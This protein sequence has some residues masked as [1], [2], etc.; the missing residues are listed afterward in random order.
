MVWVSG[1]K[2][3][4][5]ASNAGC[6]GLIGAGSMN[7][8]LLKNHIQKAH[9]LTIKPFGINIPLL[10]KDVEK[11]IEV[12]LS[13]KVKI[14][15]TSAGSPKKYTSLLQKEGCI[16]VH[17]TSS[18]DL[19]LKCQDAGVNAVV[20]EGFEAGGH[21]GRDELTTLV[22]LQQARYK[23]KIPIIAAGGIGSGAAI[24]SCLALGADAVQI[25]TLFAATLESSAHDNF[26]R[27]MCE[28]GSAST[29]LRMKKTVPVRLLENKFSNSI[30]EIED[31]GGSPEEL[32]A[33]L[34]KGR[35]KLGMLEGNLT[36]GELEIGQI[37]SE[38]H[39]ILTCDKLVDNLA[40]DFLAARARLF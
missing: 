12:A 20:L 3:A 34:N 38:I 29:F 25:G 21:N 17:V 7:P 39:E 27:A 8:D 4:A 15:F 32:L 24:A 30:K 33:C 13:E 31:R 35:A 19:A 18:V 28:A 1:A 23:L 16:V 26:K 2:L 11:Q 5:A 9:K 10:Y 22:L 14:F 36:E 37:V 40:Q 6:L